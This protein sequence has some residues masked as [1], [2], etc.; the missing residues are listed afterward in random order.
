MSVPQIEIRIMKMR[1]NAAECCLQ[2]IVRCP[3]IRRQVEDEEMI[4]F[5][6]QPLLNQTFF[7]YQGT[8][9][10][11]RMLFKKME[12]TYINRI[13]KANKQLQKTK[14]AQIDSNAD[15]YKQLKYGIDASKYLQY[16]AY[17]PNDQNNNY[18]MMSNIG[19][20]LNPSNFLHKFHKSYTEMTLKL[21][22]SLY[23]IL[24]PKSN[25]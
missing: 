5:S 15:Y 23:D 16:L 13:K 10:A 3:S 6:N 7:P 25:K 21:T 24:P 9:I 4:S 19:Q 20:A 11:R 2:M 14:V 8:L 12:K 1:V 17:I 18:S 22:M